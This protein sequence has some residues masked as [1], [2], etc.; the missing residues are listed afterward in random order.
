MFFHRLVF[1]TKSSPNS[2]ADDHL[3]VI[4]SLYS[5]FP[6]HYVITCTVLH[7]LI[8]GC[9]HENHEILKIVTVFLSKYKLIILMKDIEV[10]WRKISRLEFPGSQILRTCD[11]QVSPTSRSSPRSQKL[12]ISVHSDINRA[13][14]VLCHRPR[15]CWKLSNSAPLP[16]G[17]R[18]SQEIIHP[19]TVF[20]LY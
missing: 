16:S 19:N 9:L 6:Y 3:F 12:E 1:K 15:G 2:L 4:L 20:I 18:N 8:N 5:W 7:T 13:A 17:V 14:T 10:M 11:W